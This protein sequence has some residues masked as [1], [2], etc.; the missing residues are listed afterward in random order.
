MSLLGNLQ[1]RAGLSGG[2]PLTESYLR[3]SSRLAPFFCG[4]FRDP[5]AFRKKAREV[6][7]RMGEKGRRESLSFLLPSSPVAAAKLRGFVE[8]GGVFVTTGQQPGLLGGPLYTLYKALS[9]VSLARRLE[10]LLSRPV[11]PLFWMA[12][13]DH[14]WAEVDH[15][16]L[17][18]R[19]NEIVRFQLPEPEPPARRPLHRIPL[20]P[21]VSDLVDRFLQA[22]PPTE[23]LARCTPIL[24]ESMAPGRTLPEGFHTLLGGLMAS[25]PLLFL[26]AAQISLKRASLPLLMAELSNAGVHEELLLTTSESLRT[27]GYPVQVPVLEGA[28]NLFLEG[29]DGRE[30]LYRK[31]RGFKLARSGSEVSVEEVAAA[32]ERDPSVLSPNVILRP[33][34][35]ASLLPTVAYV[36]GPSEVAYFAQLKGLF[37]AYGVAMP[38]IVPRLSALLVEGKVGKVLEKLQLDPQDLIRPAHELAAAWS[39]GEIPQPLRSS[40]EALR[41]GLSLGTAELARQ[42]EELDPTLVGAVASTRNSSLAALDQLERKIR[43]AVRR[44]N[45]TVLEQLSKAQRH[46]FPLG[47]PQERVLNAFYY[48]TRYG[49]T[50]ID[51]LMETYPID[52]I[53]SSS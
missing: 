45:A 22:L 9:A 12:S 31:G 7:L 49:P 46:L 51:A 41:N 18:D 13:E 20:P 8:N 1:I 25:W 24:R 53:P 47:R 38:V 2:N 48:L 37:Q 33:V 34:V 29:P 39:Q 28:V 23:H 36:A 15:T 27:L 16:Y 3:G 6:D 44:R 19:N 43:Q 14:D 30:R 17:L 10:D 42:V 21:A 40:L 52:L 50:L 5:E 11:L 26:D 4:D 32:V 35:E